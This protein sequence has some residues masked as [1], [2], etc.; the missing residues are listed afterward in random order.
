MFFSDI[1]GFTELSEELEPEALTE[2]LNQYL[3]EMSKIA[4]K[5]GGTIDKFAGD[6]VVVFFGDPKSKGVKRDAL[7]A[8]SMALAM[9]QQMK[10]LHRQWL[11]AGI[12]KPLEIRMGL[13][14]G[15]CTVGNFGAY[16]RMDYTIIGQEVN[17]ASRLEKAAEAG[18]ILISHETWSLIK[19][20]ILCQAMGEIQV[21]GFTRPVATYRVLDFRRNL[22]SQKKLLEYET[23]GFSLSLDLNTV[24]EHEI[25]K[26]IKTLKVST[27]ALHSFADKPVKLEIGDAAPTTSTLRTPE[28]S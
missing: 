5:Y 24:E 20:V 4:L 15:Y 22:G 23:K 9:R 28:H 25:R 10:V 16:N 1:K 3:T 21:K 14:T 27:K 2:L 26:I 12:E 13:N 19:D 8:V 11:A 7:A 17:L 6:S 18:D